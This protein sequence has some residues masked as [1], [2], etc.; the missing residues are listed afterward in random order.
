MLCDNRH[1][2]FFMLPLHHINIMVE[3]SMFMHACTFDRNY[4]KTYM[5]ITHKMSMCL[6]HLV[7]FMQIFDFSYASE[8]DDSCLMWLRLEM[9]RF[10]ATGF[11]HFFMCD[12]LTTS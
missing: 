2:P 5:A 11:G 12:S 3:C 7:S 10:D 1:Q 8:F 9:V 4:L 6:Y